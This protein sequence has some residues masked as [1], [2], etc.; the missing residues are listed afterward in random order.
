MGAVQRMKQ[1]FKIGWAVPDNLDWSKLAVEWPEHMHGWRTGYSSDD[2]I[3]YAGLVLADSEDAAFQVI[4][5]CYAA[6]GDVAEDRD[7]TRLVPERPDW[8]RFPGVGGQW[9]R[10][11]RIRNAGQQT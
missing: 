6:C 4:V 2:K 11:D 7:M 10:L 1:I 9:D 3:H 5:D 8:S